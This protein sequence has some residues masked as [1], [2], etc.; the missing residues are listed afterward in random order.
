MAPFYEECSYDIWYS[1][2]AQMVKLFQYFGYFTVINAIYWILYII[3]FFCKSVNPK[4]QN[5]KY[6]KWLENKAEDIQKLLIFVLFFWSLVENLLHDFV[7]FILDI[8]VWPSQRNLALSTSTIWLIQ[9]CCSALFIVLK[10]CLLLF[11]I[12]WWRLN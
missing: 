6:M 7:S 3:M 2:Y 8:L 12:I 1:I 5:S 4:I 11:V 9:I 10:L